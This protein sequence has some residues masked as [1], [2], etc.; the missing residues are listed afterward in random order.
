MLT[1]DGVIFAGCA[2]GE[3][4]AW[5]LASGAP[6]ACA[7]SPAGAGV[8]ALS[9]SENELLCGTQEGELLAYALEPTVLFGEGTRGGVNWA[10]LDTDVESLG[11]G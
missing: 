6:L 10:R 2:S 11:E 1:E 3:I 7:F 4:R 8:S 9:C 5:S